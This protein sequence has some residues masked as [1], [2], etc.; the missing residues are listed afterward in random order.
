[1][2]KYAI[3]NIN[4]AVRV[5]DDVDLT[6]IF[7]RNVTLHLDTEKGGYDIRNETAA[8]GQTTNA[9]QISASAITREKGQIEDDDTVGYG[10]ALTPKYTCETVGCVDI[11]Y[12]VGLCRTCYWR[13][14]RGG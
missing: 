11:V 10:L 4:V 6:D 1:M 7:V 2:A 14:V 8:F 5:D 9:K 3:L 13:G 12:R